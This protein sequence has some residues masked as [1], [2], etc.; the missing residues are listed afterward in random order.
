MRHLSPGSRFL[1]IVKTVLAGV[2]R[3]GTIHAGNMAY[4]SIL[5]IFPFFVVGAAGFQLI[6]E[7][8]DRLAVIGA[9]LRAMPPNVAEVIGPVARSVIEAR[10]G[11]LLW[12]GALVGLW[13]IGSLI[14]TIRDILHRAY[15]TEPQLS[16]WRNRLA[17]TGVIILAVALLLVAL[18][19]QVVIGAAQEVIASYF[20]WLDSVLSSLALTRLVTGGGL[21]AS[22]YLL[23]FMLTPE[24]KNCVKC[25]RWPG[26]LA[27]TLW[28]TAVT[29]GLPPLVGTVFAYNLTYGSLA[30]IMIALFF[31]WLIGLGLVVGAQLNA[32][33]AERDE[34]ADHWDEAVQEGLNGQ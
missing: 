25:P 17:S 6:G 32:A 24:L 11:W 9:V 22:L 8:D 13:T 2:W 31:F 19:G 33:L 20:P 30:G 10:T 3:D 5:A 15:E 29:L 27:V 34:P 1:L 26:A 12:A 23:F 4:M 14:E 7:P 28:W 21:F 18:I 16:F